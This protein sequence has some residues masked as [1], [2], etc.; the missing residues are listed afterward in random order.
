MQS[1]EGGKLTPCEKAC[2]LDLK[3]STQGKGPQQSLSATGFC[4]VMQHFQ[5]RAR[6]KASPTTKRKRKK[7]GKLVGKKH[8]FARRVRNLRYVEAVKA[9]GFQ[10]D[11]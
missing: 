1:H 4:G 6:F 11:R 5:S 3:T 8:G 10:Q 7:E 9:G 2:S